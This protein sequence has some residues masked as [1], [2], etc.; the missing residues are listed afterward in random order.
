MT[1]ETISRL[2]DSALLATLSDVLLHRTLRGATPKAEPVY[3]PITPDYPWNPLLHWRDAIPLLWQHAM[4]LCAPVS[5][6]VDTG[7]VNIL[8][9]HGIDSLS[10]QTEADARRAICQLTLYSLWEDTS[11]A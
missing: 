2:D 4:H 10:V 9:K 6:G 5:N 1:F 7:E 3:P 8:N 11:H